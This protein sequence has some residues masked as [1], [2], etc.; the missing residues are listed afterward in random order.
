V[1][2]VNDCAS[3]WHMGVYGYMGINGLPWHMGV[4]GYMGINGLP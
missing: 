3:L 1:R 4:Y 2:V